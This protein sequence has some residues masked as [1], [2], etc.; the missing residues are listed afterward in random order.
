MSGSH[1]RVAVIGAGITGLSAAYEAALTG[2]DRVAVTLFDGAGRAGG[3]IRTSTFAGLRVDEGADAFLRRVPDALE[4]ARSVGIDERL[5]S[6]TAG[7][8]AVWVDGLRRLPE[9]LVLGVPTSAAALARSRLVSPAVQSE[10]WLMSSCRDGV[11]ITTRSACGFVD[12]SARRCT[13]A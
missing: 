10:P 5:T 7:S 12:G 3:L 9:G 1:T 2:G 4:L 11:S 6:P 13:T 8:A